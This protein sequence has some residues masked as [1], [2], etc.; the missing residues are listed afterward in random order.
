MRQADQERQTTNAIGA[1]N[2]TQAQQLE[3]QLVPGYTSL[4][5]T[6][7]LSP[8]E[9]AAATTSEMGATTAPFKSAEFQAANRASATGNA[10]DL[11][12]QQDQLALEEGQAA[13]GTA[14]NLQEQQMQNQLAGMYGLA[15]QEQGN[16]A[17]TASMYGLSPALLNAGTNAVNSTFKGIGT[18][19]GLL[20]LGGK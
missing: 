8:E 19:G 20:G 4:M 16:Q 5:N 3:S 9:K 15:G 18:V 1:Q 2:N 17:Q 7:Y 11:T 13:G 14:A 10:S 6:G 12:A